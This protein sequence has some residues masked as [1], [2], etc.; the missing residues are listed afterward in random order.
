VFDVIA[1][2]NIS[3]LYYID[4]WLISDRSCLLT[5]SECAQ[6]FTI[7]PTTNKFNLYF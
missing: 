2:I 1:Q 4:N 7:T 3:L 6:G 5:K